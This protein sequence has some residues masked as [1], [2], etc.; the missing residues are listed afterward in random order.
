LVNGESTWC[1]YDAAA[2]QLTLTLHVQPAAR[3][4]GI[5]GIHG[6]ALKIRIAAP[7]SDN[8]ANGALVEFLGEI[9]G[10]PKSAITIRRGATGRR[11]VVEIAGGP[12]LAAKL[13]E[14]G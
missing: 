11:K 6:D 13:S 3:K 9:L 7:A 12:E 10:V 4:S 1:R 8:K 14:P 5:A 2:R